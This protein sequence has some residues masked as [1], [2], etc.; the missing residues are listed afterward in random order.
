MQTNERTDRKIFLVDDDAVFL[1]SLEI[2]ILVS[3]LVKLY[4]ANLGKKTRCD[5]SR[6]SFRWYR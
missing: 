2:D 6:L 3:T 4:I 1:K 5:H